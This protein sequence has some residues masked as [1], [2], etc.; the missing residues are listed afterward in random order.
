MMETGHLTIW[1]AACGAIAVLTLLSIASAVR[2]STRAAWRMT[3]W[4]LGAFH[5]VLLLSGLAP[6]VYPA[7]SGPVELICQVWIGP[8]W[9]ALSAFFFRFTLQPWQRNHWTVVT[10]LCIC[11]SSPSLMALALVLAPGIPPLLIS[12]CMTLTTL[13]ALVVVA[14]F[15][16]WRGATSSW[17]IALACLVAMPI[18]AAMFAQPLGVYLDPRPQ[19]FLAIMTV[20]CCLGTATLL[21]P[22]DA[23]HHRARQKANPSPHRDPLTQLYSSAGIVRKLV[24]ATRRQR[25]F[26]GSGALVAIMVFQA[27]RVITQFDQ[28]T[29]DR[30]YIT[31]GARIQLVAGHMNPVGRYGSDCFLVVVEAAQSAQGLDDM[32][33]TLARE[34]RVP[35]RLPAEKHGDDA[36]VPLV[37][38]GQVT[39]SPQI[40]VDSLLFRVQEVARASV[41]DRR[42]AQAT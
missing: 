6:L 4:L 8:L 24:A 39:L 21:Q 31:L 10:L 13:A 26:G 27:E 23:Y 32:L 19:A 7:I 28:S 34:L 18:L 20:L 16:G 41:V 42:W 17:G 25:W 22:R 37:G 33:Q 1:S 11:I 38:L 3:V 12:A 15:A 2:Y 40:T 36:V 35:I 14:V 29:L 30:V 5:V 9:L